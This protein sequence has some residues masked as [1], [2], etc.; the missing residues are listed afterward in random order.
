MLIHITWTYIVYMQIVYTSAEDLIFPVDV[1]PVARA[2]IFL[3]SVLSNIFTW[4]LRVLQC[5]AVCCSVLQCGARCFGV[6]LCATVCCS[7]FTWHLRVFSE[8]W[9]RVLSID[10][11]KDVRRRDSWVYSKRHVY[12]RKEIYISDKRD[13]QIRPKSVCVQYRPTQ[14]RTKKRLVCA[15]V[16]R[17]RHVYHRKETYVLD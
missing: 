5:G 3:F 1:Q 15:R 16:Y 6:L 13:L 7:V 12:Q 4:Y 14:R 10:E 11:Q 17:K 8:Q 2:I 9:V